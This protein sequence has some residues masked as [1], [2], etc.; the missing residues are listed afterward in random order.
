MRVIRRIFDKCNFSCDSATETDLDFK[1][2]FQQ[3]SVDCL[4]MRERPRYAGRLVVR[5]PRTLLTA[6]F[7]ELDGK[8]LPSTSLFLEDLDFLRREVRS[9]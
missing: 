3:A 9:C 6:L 5:R 2:R 1:E 7:L 8:R 4:L